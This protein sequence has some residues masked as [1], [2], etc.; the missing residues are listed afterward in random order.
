MSIWRN[1]RGMRPYHLLLLAVLVAVVVAQG[2][3]MVMLARSQ[4]LKAQA[5]DALERSARAA[6]NAPSAINASAR[7][8]TPAGDGMIN[9]GFVAS[10]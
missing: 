6:A 7:Q 1:L 3:A 8:S 2:A 4:V 9:V 10:R 5:R